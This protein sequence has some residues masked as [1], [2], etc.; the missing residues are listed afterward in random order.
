MRCAQ[1]A[2]YHPYLQPAPTQE[3]AAE[4][5]DVPFSTYRQHLKSGWQRIAEMLWQAEVGG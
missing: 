3:Q 1:G 4:L 2:V 5:L